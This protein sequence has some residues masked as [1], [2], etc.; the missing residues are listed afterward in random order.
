MSPAAA[1]RPNRPVGLRRQLGSTTLCL[2]SAVGFPAAAAVDAE[3]AGADHATAVD[4]VQVTARRPT[5]NLLTDKVLDVP[6]TIGVISQEILRDQN[7]ASLQDAL[8]NT[9][10]IT[11]N[12]GEGG[13]HGDSINLRGF[14]ASDDFFLDGLRDTGFY[15]RD[16]FDYDSV[17]IY[18]GP[19]STLFGRGSTGGVVN[20][21][22]K[23]PRLTPIDTAA[24]TI[25]TSSE[26][27]GVIDLN[28]PISSTAA[29]RL[30][31]MGFSSQV[32]G[33]DFVLNRR[34][35]VAP[36][37]SFGIGTPTTLTL[38]YLHQSEDNIPDY[39]IPFIGGKPAP[40]A[41]N[42]YYGLPADDRSI[43]DVD[44]ITMRL[45]HA[46]SDSLSLSD[47]F[48]FG[49]Y[50]FDTRETA[51]H[52][53]APNV[54]PGA[55]PTLSPCTL[56]TQPTGPLDDIVVCRDRPSV[57]GTVRTF[58]NRAA[59]N[60]H[61]DTGP[62]DH[63]LVAGLDLDEE[64]AD[65]VRYANQI[66]QVVPTPL[67]NPNPNEAFP[68][69][70]SMASQRPDTTT[71]TVGVFVL[72]TI[73]F[74]PHWNLV[75]GVR[76]DNFT[77][78]FREPIARAAFDHT[79]SIASPRAALVYKPTDRTSLYFS[80]GTSFDP[81]AENLSLSART[82]DL[83][84]E[85]DR[86]FEIGAKAAVLNNGLQ[87]SGALFDTEMTNARVGDPTNPTL[88]ILA[89]DQRVRGLEL[90][91]LGYL[92]RKW[93][94]LAGY[95]YLDAR[96]I[97]STDPTQVGQLLP[98]TAHNQANLWTTYEPT[99]D[100]KVGAGL[101]YLGRREADVQ[102]LA[103]IPSYVTWDGMVS[104]AVNRNLVLQ[105]NGYNLLDKRYFTNAYYSS[106]VENHVLL[107]AGRT[108]SLT[109]LLRY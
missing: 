73:Q 51:P 5:L 99:E 102:G 22:S 16:S 40:V 90:N 96:T 36:S 18:K 93:E 95:T 77:A 38:S 57:A 33:R 37:A 15:T 66:G 83:G 85:K 64:S 55:S 21:V 28:Q 44:I 78:R 48:R 23:T 12:A 35:A 86:T 7:V 14:P 52:Y 82:A 105:V 30:D 100:W 69:R 45:S 80:Y 47:D 19:A 92:T 63:T 107:G 13:S 74:G 87:L 59:V 11:L 49:N 89:G 68:G 58:M 108:V 54:A 2:A 56:E 72:D 9:P 71:D 29:L 91:A 20:A 10:G 53:G 41:R 39:G 97:K 109:A 104:Y 75:A 70:Q 81:S 24:L 62:L 46:F 60:D 6:Q 34:W 50:Y 106:P 3:A 101:N 88:Q 42:A 103:H 4:E 1:N 61:F 26:Y 43:A 17:E 94:I 25:G 67:L 84:P 79:D 65:L 31:A 98:N 27:R 8:K 32:A 76:Y